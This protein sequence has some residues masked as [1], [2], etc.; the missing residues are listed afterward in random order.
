MSPV[1]LGLVLA[2]PLVALTGEV[3]PAAALRRAGLLATPEERHEPPVLAR[4]RA[5]VV[6]YADDETQAIHRLLADRTLL[7]AHRAMLPPPRRPRVDPLDASLLLAVAKIDEALSLDGAV[8]ALSRRETA[9]V[10][11]NDAGLAR[12]AALAD[13]RN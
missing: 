4:A 9:S 12:L 3:A 2:I 13:T 1:L 11:L 7:A 10:L 8:A 6:D 5:L